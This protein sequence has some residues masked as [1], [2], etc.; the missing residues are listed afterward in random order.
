MIVDVAINKPLWK[1]LDYEVSENIECSIGSVVEVPFRNS[2]EIGL[3]L[4][5]KQKS[6][7]QYNL[8]KINKII[9]LSFIN[10][11]QL[12]LLNF[13]SSYYCCPLGITATLFYSKNFFSETPKKILLMKTLRNSQ[14]MRKKL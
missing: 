1:T 10:T 4:G 11:E 2:T 8:K 3:V 9:E 14:V 5:I 7:G 6:S 13:M 12:K